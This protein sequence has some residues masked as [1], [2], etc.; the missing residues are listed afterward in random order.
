MVNLT[1]LTIHQMKTSVKLMVE[2]GWKM[3]I[4]EL[5][6]LQNMEN[7]VDLGTAGSGSLDKSRQSAASLQKR[8]DEAQASGF[9]VSFPTISSVGSGV[10]TIPTK[11]GLKKYTA[12]IRDTKTGTTNYVDQSGQTVFTSTGM[13]TSVSPVEP[14]S[15]TPTDSPVGKNLMKTS[16]TRSTELA[17]RFG[18]SAQ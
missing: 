5:I 1:I 17:N 9:N 7:L 4:Q 12:I 16:D 14:T 13:P 3:E 8:I 15:P 10:A 18:G 2:L 6:Y 11:D